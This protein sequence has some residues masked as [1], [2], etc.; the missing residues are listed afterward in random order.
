MILKEGVKIQ[1]I[2]TE[3]LFG[4]NVADGVYK[5]HGQELTITSLLDGKHSS[6]SLHYSGNAGDLRTRD[7][8]KEL[9]QPIRDDIKSKLGIDFDVILESDHIHMEY[10]PRRT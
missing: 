6:T 7:V 2:S 8:P 10:Q 3:L 5:D 1:G 9:H 4:L